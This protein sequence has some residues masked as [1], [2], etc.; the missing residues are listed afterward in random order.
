[1]HGSVSSGS[2]T[3]KPSRGGVGRARP[4]RDPRVV[5]LALFTFLLAASAQTSHLIE[6]GDSLWGIAKKYGTTPQA[7][8]EANHI[9]NPSLI[10]IGRSLVIPSGSAMKPVA[11]TQQWNGK[12]VV[13][14]GEN[15]TKIAA[16]YGASVSDL[17]KVNSLKNASMVRA[18]ATLAV[19]GPPPKRELSVEELLAHYGKEFRVDPALV[20]AIAWQESGWKQQV[21]STAGAVGV[22]QVIPETGAFTG[23]HLLGG[24]EVDLNNLDHNVKAGVR[25]LAYLLAHTRG[26]EKLAVAGYFQGLRSVRTMGITPKTE[27]YVANVMALKKRFSG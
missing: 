9:A 16:K 12:H 6:A 11:H 2:G 27:R 8:A 23:R 13:A 18:G 25:F 3:R 24:M 17:A 7:I 19:P 1:M 15:L 26:D 5:L 22:M 4:V 20:K 14:R 21:V 10:I